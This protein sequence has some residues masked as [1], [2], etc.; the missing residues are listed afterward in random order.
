MK[1]MEFSGVFDIGINHKKF[2]NNIVYYK[3]F[4][5]I[6]FRDL[7]Y[8][9]IK[10]VGDIIITFTELM[11]HP[12][13]RMYYELSLLLIDNK[14]KVIES[15]SME[16]CYIYPKDS[17]W[18]IDGVQYVEDFTTK[19]KKIEIGKYCYYFNINPNDLK[20]MKVSNDTDI[21]GFNEVLYI[22][23][24]YE[25][26]IIYKE[27]FVD[28]TN[29]MI[30]YNIKLIEED[31]EKI[32]ASHEDDKNFFNLLELNKKG[33]NADVFNML[34][35]TVISDKGRKKLNYNPYA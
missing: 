34:Y 13:L 17:N 14:H 7:I 1:D 4:L 19:V 24:G 3:Y 5:F 20:N 30:E 9:D 35:N 6:K 28:Y 8:I 10:N 21:A 32:S 11:K 31:I 23:Y 22:R 29:L 15:K 26:G 16:S 2:H 27:L 18:F 25:H 12:Y 33:M